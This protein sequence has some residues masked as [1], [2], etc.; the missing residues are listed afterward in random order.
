MQLQNFI[1]E[2][3]FIG[4]DFKQNAQTAPYTTFKIG[5]YADVLII[6]HSISEL[7]V[8]KSLCE[9]HLL[10]HKILGGGSNVL[11]A[12]EGFRG[13]I[14]INKI[15]YIE[16]LDKQPIT[17]NLER[18]RNDVRFSSDSPQKQIKENTENV[19][20]RVGAGIKIPKLI[21][22]LFNVEVYGLEYFAGIPA[23]VGGAVY[24]NMHGADLFLGDIV[25]NILLYSK[26]EIKIVP[27]SYFQFG[28][29]YSILH[30]T[31]EIV[32]ACDLL[33]KKGN[34]T[35]SKEI[36]REWLQKKRIQPQR[37]AGCIFQNI[38]SEMQNKLGIPTPSV[39]Y[40]I[41]KILGMKGYTV[42]GA[43]I[44]ESHAAFIENS[45]NATATDVRKL[46]EEIQQKALSQLELE[47]HTEIEYIGY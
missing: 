40:V 44:S 10:P 9:K 46:I 21:N 36:V 45:N 28:Y 15:E 8:I 12:D 18:N 38:T 19:I 42:G 24:M 32:L 22:K 23:T 14:I 1:K 43:K 31:K 33:L 35:A 2:V 41:D 4:L 47:L 29:D 27:P 6:A 34:T 11:I 13:V 20:V 30:K 39:G 17:I 37:S 7:C 16:V 25:T 3:H 5:G 26:G